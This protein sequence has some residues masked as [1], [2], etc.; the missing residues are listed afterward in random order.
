MRVL[1]TLWVAGAPLTLASLSERTGSHVNT[2]RDHLAALTASGLV[3]CVAAPSVGARRG[4]PPLAYRALAGPSPRA[5]AASLLGALARE[6]G[7]LPDAEDVSLRAGRRWGEALA[8][9]PDLMTGLAELGF[10]PKRVED[11][12]V[13]RACPVGGVAAGTPEVICLMHLGALQAVLPDDA[14]ELL[15]GG[16]PEGCLLRLPPPR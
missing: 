6:V 1:A 11:G 5:D 4:R 13:L 15:P 16:H 12:V 3:E 9:A 2:L 10:S 7:G 14:A 8:G